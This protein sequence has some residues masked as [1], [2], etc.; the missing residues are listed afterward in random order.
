MV[1]TAMR[2]ERIEK[3]AHILT[4]YSIPLEAGRTAV[5]QGTTL[6]EPLMLA[7]YER[8][9]KRGVHPYLR[10][11]FPHAERIFFEH[12]SDAQL[13]FLWEPDL[14]V[15]EKIDA[16]YV[17][18]AEPNT[19]QLSKIDPS[20]QAAA[21][22]ARKPIMDTFLRRSASK[23][24]LWVGTLLP[25]EAYAMDAGMSLADYED[26]Y[27][28]A[29]L[30]D[31]PDPIAQWRAMAGRHQRL[32]DW[33]KGRNLVHIEGEGTDLYLEVGGRVF[34]PANGNYNFPDG[35]FF[36]APIEDRTRGVVSF[37]YPAIW[38]GKSVE[39]IRLEFDEGHVVSATSRSNQEFLTQMLD[40][41]DG[42]RVL[43]ELGIGTNYGI[44][45]FSGT[46]LLDEK[47]GGTV[48]LALGAAYPE[49]GGLNQSA[50][51]WDM[52]CDLRQGGRITV[53]GELLME[54]GKLL[55]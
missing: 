42:S 8:L 49:T 26:F 41:D 11:I 24:L 47:I 34:E 10:P 20:R 4:E 53:D 31:H 51:H 52:V 5:V 38:Q 28:G 45:Q 7:I 40:T 50:I 30:L 21:A 29:C 17:V 35:E 44:K 1:V 2:D 27:Y 9:L 23:Q 22:R 15:M 13:A 3:V 48:H 12:A 6:A 18:I 33:M 32:I 14:W 43:G 54:D 55:V 16:R 36:T 37:S 46:I 19:K 25:T 39:G